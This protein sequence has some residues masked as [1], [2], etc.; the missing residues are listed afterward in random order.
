MEKELYTRITLEQSMKK[1]SWE[2]PFEDISASD[3]LDAFG[4]IALCLGFSPSSIIEAAIH[5][6]NVHSVGWEI[7]K[8]GLIQ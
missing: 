7:A 5:F 2:I 8:D 3:I 4:T 1:A 6:V